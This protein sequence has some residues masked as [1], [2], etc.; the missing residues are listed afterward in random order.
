MLKI[1]DNLENEKT[2]R[3]RLDGTLSAETFI[4]LTHA[5][6]MHRNDS[7]RI[8]IL[9]MAGVEYM[10]GQIARQLVNLRSENLRIINCSP[11]IEMLL[12]SSSNEIG[13]E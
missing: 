8:V 4:E 11:F 13:N 2:V 7:E 6:A 5:C 10:N 9:D 12:E 1:T 3:L